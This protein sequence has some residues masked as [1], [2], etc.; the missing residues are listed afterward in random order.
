MRN[1]SLLFHDVYLREP[2]ESGFMSVGADRYKVS[3]AEFEA[4]LRG[5]ADVRED[6]PRLA[7]DLI[8]RG[9]L[10]RDAGSEMP[11]LLPVDDGGVSYFTVVADRLEARGWRG[12]CFVTTD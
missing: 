4:Q 9:A 2:Q 8:A 3:V 7:T 11:F 6:A 5:I 10:R 1:V 12:H